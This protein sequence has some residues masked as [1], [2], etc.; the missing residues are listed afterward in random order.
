MLELKRK[1]YQE[2]R[3]GCGVHANSKGVKTGP[4]ELQNTLGCIFSY[5]RTWTATETQKAE[6]TEKSKFRE[7]IKA[8]LGDKAMVSNLGSL[9]AVWKAVETTAETLAIL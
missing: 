7:K 2:M 4:L 5:R 1:G 9:R 6:T 8:R 3:S